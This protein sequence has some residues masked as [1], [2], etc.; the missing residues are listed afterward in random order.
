MR[1]GLSR[2]LRT[3]ALRAGLVVAG[4]ALVVVALP[5][6]ASASTGLGGPIRAVPCADGETCQFSTD[7]S[8][9]FNI[10][11]DSRSNVGHGFL[12][13][14]TSGGLEWS[15]SIWDDECDNKGVYVDVAGHVYSTA[16]CNAAPTTATI[17]QGITGWHVNWG[18]NSPNGISYVYPMVVN[19]TG[20]WA[21][22][23]ACICG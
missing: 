10:T 12:H 13:R 9:N 20:K 7:T 8:G 4:A 15:L 3:T 5:G 23:P 14:L 6:S 11:V 21:P 2:M 22:P 16:G 17:F 1:F 19:T 18:G